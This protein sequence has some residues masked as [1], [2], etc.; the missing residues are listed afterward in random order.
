MTHRSV[1]HK[2][3]IDVAE[4][5]HDAAL[6]F[7]QGAV[8]QD[9]PQYTRFP[10]YHGA[11]LDG[12]RIGLLVQRIGGG[13]SRIHIDIHASDV[14]AEVARLE[15]LGAERVDEREYWT[16]MRDPGGLLFCVVVDDGLD[17]SNSHRWE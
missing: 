14:A 15:Q 12:Q 9:L 16:V 11:M 17:D 7:W 6:A 4:P 8:G 3:V 13:P 2:V 5:A 10:E 1:I